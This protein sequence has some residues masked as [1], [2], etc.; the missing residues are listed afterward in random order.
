MDAFP[1]YTYFDQ[2]KKVLCVMQ[3]VEDATKSA[4]YGNPVMPHDDTHQHDE[5]DIYNDPYDAASNV[6]ALKDV[7]DEHTALKTTGTSH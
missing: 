5:A 3:I 2:T 7:A 4:S 6:K 1:G